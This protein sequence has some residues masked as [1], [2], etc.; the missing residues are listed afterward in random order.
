M[1]ICVGLEKPPVVELVPDSPDEAGVVPSGV[2]APVVV[3]K[4][5]TLP[6]GVVNG[7]YVPPVGVTCSNVWVSGLYLKYPVDGLPIVVLEAAV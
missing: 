5:T 7:V 1:V 3:L 4:S 2:A 6:S